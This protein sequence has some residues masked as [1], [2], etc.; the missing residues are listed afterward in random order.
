[1]ADQFTA[2]MVEE[3]D[4]RTR[5]VFKELT[6]DALPDH[7]V[8]VAVAYSGLNYKDGL[9]VTGKG[10]ICRKLPMVAGIDLAG[11]VV[12]SRSPLWRPGDRVLVTGCNLS[13]TEWGGYS[14]MQR[15]KA[16]WCVRVPERFTL[17][18]AMAI[19]TAGFTAMLAVLGLEHMGVDP[20]GREVVVTGAGGGVGSVA[21]AILARLGYPVVAVTGRPD[22]QGYLKGLGAA[23]FLD[24]STLETAGPGLQRER[25]AG[26]VDSVGGVMLANIVAQTA[27]QGCIAV[28]G[29]AAGSDLPLTVFPLILRGVSL[30][31][32]NSVEV[33]RTRRDAAWR[34]LA[35]DLDPDTLAAMTS[36]APLSNIHILAEDIVAG[37]VRGRTVVDVNR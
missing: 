17:L 13:E 7:D 14:Q 27:R 2:L 26:G 9:A 18:Q 22:V 31:G 23:S 8:L 29:L 19:G 5:A 32:V 28:C 34:R 24:R 16:E 21:V 10:K 35:S 1:M 37:R 25:W 33:S 11:T 15:V 6:T 20:V 4:G 30:Y 36:V 12:E 3:C